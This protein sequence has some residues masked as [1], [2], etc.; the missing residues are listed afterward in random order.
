[1]LKAGVDLGKLCSP[2][3]HL[4][5]LSTWQYPCAVALN[6]PL[7]MPQIG[8]L[9]P[10]AIPFYFCTVLNAGKVLLRMNQ[11]ELLSSLG[12]N[13]NEADHNGLHVLNT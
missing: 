5:S 6:S 9:P 10:S 13:T 3:P 4:I 1:M 2:T 8:Q 12:N 11:H 7:D